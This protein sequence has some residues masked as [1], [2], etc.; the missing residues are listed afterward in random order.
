MKPVIKNCYLS[1][2]TCLF[3]ATLFLIQSCKEDDQI[4]IPEISEAIPNKARQ[5][6]KVKILGRYFDAD[7]KDNDVRFRGVTA[8]VLSA[9]PTELTVVVPE[10]ISTGPY[11]VRVGAGIGVSPIDFEFIPPPNIKTFTPFK[12]HV[13]DELTVV[14]EGIS[15]KDDVKVYFTGMQDPGPLATIDHI[16]QGL[17]TLF[18][19]VPPGAVSGSL[20]LVTEG[21]EGTSLLEFALEDAPLI[22]DFNPKVAVPGKDVVVITGQLFGQGIENN[23]VT[24]SGPD[25]E[26]PLVAEIQ[27]ANETEITVLVPEGT[28][29]GPIVV[30]NLQAEKMAV[31]AE[32]FVPFTITSFEPQVQVE[33][34]NITITGSGFSETIAENEVGFF[35]D[36]MGTVVSATPTELVVTVPEG[37]MTGPIGVTVGELATSTEADFTPVAGVSIASFDPMDGKVDDEVTILGIG[38]GDV[39]SDIM[40]Q[41]NGTEAVVNTIVDN[42]LTVT[43]PDGISTGPISV[44]VQKALEVTTTSAE[45]FTVTPNFW[46]SQD[47]GS[48]GQP[49]TLIS[50]TGFSAVLENNVVSFDTEEATVLG[51]SE[52]GTE[53][54]VEVPN[55]NPGDI[56]QLGLAV[57]GV[58]AADM[59]DFWIVPP[60]KVLSAES[61]AFGYFGQAVAIEGNM[62]F[63]GAPFSN[64]VYAYENIDGYWL[65]KQKLVA[66][67]GMEGNFGRS[68]EVNKDLLLIGAPNQ[69]PIG[70]VYAFSLNGENQWIPNEKI[71]ALNDNTSDSFGYAISIYNDLAVIGAPYADGNESD[72]GA[73]Y[74]F[75]TSNWNQIKKISSSDGSTGDS[76]GEDVAVYGDFIVAGA[77]YD[78]G[79]S[80][81]SGSAYIFERNNGDWD[82][83]TK[84]ENESEELNDL[85][86]T[87]V[88]IFGNYI[89]IGA[90]NDNINLNSN[91]G[92]VAIYKHD[93]GVWTKEHVLL[94]DDGTSGEYFGFDVS[95]LNNFALIASRYSNSIGAAYLFNIETGQPIQKLVAPDP[96]APGSFFKV[97]LSE[98]YMLLGDSE[99]GDKGVHSGSA[100]IFEY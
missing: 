82:V 70:A 14:A 24:F 27:S 64:A 8:E 20:T 44:T 6:A 74:L 13:G 75:N 90:P 59:E 76:L 98:N 79:L 12:G 33:G 72:S 57:N 83:E 30:T 36:V 16:T 7:L 1:L 85:F 69:N 39:I 15:L 67:D 97:S 63:I 61:Y 41:F 19:T 95:V 32:N 3:A 66:N 51:L 25:P 68:I 9:S 60:G 93:F 53:L 52:D 58:A 28:V 92:S 48:P 29:Q 43:V 73:I 49:I 45:E 62:V 50:E 78:D 46:L 96:Q 22:E 5:G 86:G 80:E 11:T 71:T 47:F 4:P 65:F 17:D 38:F 89:A 84:L 21:M 54:V 40:V 10:K 91:Q 55:V 31:S 87:S 81:N 42:E 56:V 23:V 100:Y 26:T 37:A 99:D 77:P 34:Q 2:F 35:G 94:A 88:D 18:I